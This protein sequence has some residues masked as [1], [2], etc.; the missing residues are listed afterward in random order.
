MA[1]EQVYG[2][3][4]VLAALAKNPAGIEGVWLSA[5][6]ADA[7]I[8]EVERAAR[9]ASVPIHRVAR[10]ELEAMAEGLRHQGVVARLRRGPRPGP[11]DFEDF[12]AALPP[13]P[14]LLILDGVQDP[15]NLGACLRSAEAAGAHAVIVPKDNS[16]P[17]SDVARKSASGAAETVPLFRVTNLARTLDALKEAGVWTI[18]ATHDAGA[19]LYAADLTGP[20]ALVLGGEGK[21]LRRLTRERCDLLVS[22]PMAGTVGSL[23][24]SVAAG[25]CLFEAVRQRRKAR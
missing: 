2:L 12:L 24:V 4:A 11:Q 17:L 21:G 20:A 13:K 19:T 16:A 14:L 23:N 9:A 7:R 15:H 8:A 10:E 5:G 1:E 22:I 25:I 3:H 18:G 6:R